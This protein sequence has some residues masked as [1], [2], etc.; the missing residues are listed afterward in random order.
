MSAL[1]IKQ[2]HYK[3]RLVHDI[4]EVDVKFVVEQWESILKKD[5]AALKHEMMDGRMT[6]SRMGLR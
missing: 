4:L 5:I 2:Q 6:G 1:K 3:M